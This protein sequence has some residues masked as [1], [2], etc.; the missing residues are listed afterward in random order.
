MT[1]P[2]APPAADGSRGGDDPPAGA[3][4][5]TTVVG[6]PPMPAAPA[7]VVPPMYWRVLRL[8][9]VR[10]NGWQRAILVEGVIGLSIVLALADVASAWTVLVLPLVTMAIVMAHDYLAGVLDPGR[11]SAPPPARAADYAWVVGIPVAILLLRVLVH[12]SGEGRDTSLIVLGVLLW[13]G[14]A[15][16]V[17]R[18]LV[19]RGVSKDRAAAIGA[20]TFLL[21]PLAG[22][23]GAALEARRRRMEGAGRPASPPYEPR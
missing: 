14:I 16:L 9:A 5:G 15:V 13:L 10:P 6:Y 4:P 19:R 11:R 18:Y 21:S 1:S 17:Y 20:V 7:P 2:F 12:P 23:L 22:A 8:S 3:Q